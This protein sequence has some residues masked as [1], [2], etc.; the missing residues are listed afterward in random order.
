MLEIFPLD[1]F[2]LLTSPPLFSHL[3]FSRQFCFYF[4]VIYIPCFTNLCKIWE[5]HKRGSS[6]TSSSPDWLSSHNMLIPSY[7]HFPTRDITLFSLMAGKF[8]A[9]SLGVSIFIV[10]LTLTSH[11]TVV[12]SNLIKVFLFLPLVLELLIRHI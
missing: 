11:Y 10:Y 5:S 8:L 1:P 4:H 3:T 7:I 2:P 9:C 6:Q 12:T